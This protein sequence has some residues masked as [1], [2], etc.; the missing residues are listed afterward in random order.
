MKKLLI[1]TKKEKYIP[2]LESIVQK[3]EMYNWDVYIVVEG[4][5][6]KEY[7]FLNYNVF[8]LR[9]N[10]RLIDV[11]IEFVSILINIKHYED[12]AGLNSREVMRWKVLIE[13]I[14]LNNPKHKSIIIQSIFSIFNVLSLSFLE[15]IKNYYLNHNDLSYRI[16]NQNFDKIIITPGNNYPLFEERFFTKTKNAH[17][18]IYLYTL[19]WDNVA[20]K[21][22]VSNR[23]YKYFTVN[24]FQKDYLINESK[25]DEN[26]IIN[27][28]SLNLERIREFSMTNSD[29]ILSQIEKF[30]Q[31]K[32]SILFIGG[33]EHVLKNELEVFKKIKEILSLNPHFSGYDYIYRPHPSRKFMENTNFKGFTM[34]SRFGLPINEIQISKY[35][36]LILKSSFA[37]GPPTSAFLEI[38]YLNIPI[39]QLNRF[40]ENNLIPERHYLDFI[41][42]INPIVINSF[43]DLSDLSLKIITESKKAQEIENPKFLQDLQLQKY[44]KLEFPSD[45]IFN[46]LSQQVI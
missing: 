12:V 2:V 8:E 39:L 32:N 38:D 24:E 23:Y 19:S 3:F 46:E 5:M 16:I 36:D 20:T 37:I 11:L 18:P 13:K 41:K 44:N 4:Q 1:I 45:I 40:D 26:K 30:K 43:E 9:V 31:N 34:D 25:I 15:K 10:R 7:K 21:G 29:K 27:S 35:I 14:L 42:Y 33:S 17:S 22:K 28:G 6:D